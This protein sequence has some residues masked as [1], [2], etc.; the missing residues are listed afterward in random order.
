MSVCVPAGVLEVVATL[1]VKVVEL[2]AEG[3]EMLAGLVDEIETP[4]GI[5]PCSETAMPKLPLLPLPEP[6]LTTTLAY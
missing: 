5:G 2:A 1:R 3:I 4:A 6:L